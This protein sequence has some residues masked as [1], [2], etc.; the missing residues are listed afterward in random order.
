[1]KRV[2]T[3]AQEAFHAG[4]VLFHDWRGVELVR[5]SFGFLGSGTGAKAHRLMGLAKAISRRPLGP[6]LGKG[7]IWY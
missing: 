7:R 6:V 5:G 3:I 2:L 1:M 4:S